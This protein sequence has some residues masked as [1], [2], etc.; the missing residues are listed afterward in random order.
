M[1]LGD[2][3]KYPRYFVNDEFDFYVRIDNKGGKQIIVYSDEEVADKFG[4]KMMDY[5]ISR[6]N[7][8][9]REVRKEEIPLIFGWI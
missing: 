7:P 1:G 9:W 2:N 4:E 8:N 5:R 6:K 3:M